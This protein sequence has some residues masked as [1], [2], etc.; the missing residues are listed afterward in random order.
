MELR[1]RLHPLL[2]LQLREICKTSHAY[3]ACLA[4]VA[5]Q[6][7]AVV[8]RHGPEILC[9]AINPLRA[10]VDDNGCAVSAFHG[11]SGTVFV[12]LDPLG[13]ALGE[14]VFRDRAARPRHGVPRGR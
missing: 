13:T 10:P 1:V 7:M 6:A 8:A 11:H 12:D 9:A 14:H 2:R 3:R 4:R 5:A